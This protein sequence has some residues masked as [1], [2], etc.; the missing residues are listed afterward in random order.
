MTSELYFRK[1]SHFTEN[2]IYLYLFLDDLFFK[3][4]S[5]W[6]EKG[7]ITHQMIRLLLYC[8]L[9]LPFCA[10]LSC[11]SQLSDKAP[12]NRSL[13]ISPEI[14]NQ[15]ISSFAEDSVGH[16]WI[17]TMRGLNKFVVNEF[18]QY[19]SRENPNSLC[20]DQVTQVFRDSRNRLW[21]GTRGGI[22]R[23]TDRDNFERVPIE[24]VSQNVVE[25][26]EDSEG[27]I[28]L[29][30]VGQLCEYQDDINGF[31]V[32]IPNF[33]QEGNWTTRCFTDRNAQ[34]WAVSNNEIRCYETKNL[35]LL[36]STAINFYPHYYF[37]NGNNEIWLVSSTRLTVFDTQT[38]QFLP[39]PTAVQNHPTLLNSIITFVFQYSEK[40]FLLNT[41]NG[42]YLYN[43][44][45]QTVV[46][47]NED[48]FP[49]PA[50]NFRVSTAFLD[51]R[52][53]L[54]LGSNEQG[55]T[56][57]YSY[58]KHFNTNNYLFQ[59]FAG[60]SVIST[61]TDSKDN[62]FLT[63]SNDDVFMYNAKNKTI[64]KI[65][66]K[67]FFPSTEKKYKNRIRSIF[68]DNQ[69]FV[70]LIAEMNHLFR[71]RL[72]GGKFVLEHDFWLPTTVNC[73]A[74]DND[75]NFYAAGFNEN[76]YILKHG[77]TDFHPIEM[78]KRGMYMFTNGLLKLRNGK[79]LVA[80]FHSNL[81]LLSEGGAR[82]DA[83][84]ILSFMKKNP[85]FVPTAVFEDSQGDIWIG[86]L[87]NGLFR[88]S[89]ITEKMEEMP[90]DCD[91]ITSIQEDLQRNIWMGTLFGLT[92]YDH[93]SGKM[94][95][96]YKADGTGGNQFNE[97]ASCR[98]ADGTLIFGGTHGLTFFN[99]SET[100]EKRHIPL[101][102]ENLKINNR[103]VMPDGKI[104]DRHLSYNPVI[105]LQHNENNIMISYSALD[106]AEFPRMRYFCKMESAD[107]NWREMDSRREIYFSNLAP[108]K[109]TFHVK[110]MNH[111]QTVT[112]GENAI[113]IH[114]S[115]AWWWSW[116]AKTLYVL[117]LT[118]LFLIIYKIIKNTR[119]NQSL[120]RQ[121]ELEKEQEKR[122]NKMN[123]N[124]FTNVSHEFRTP[125]TM[126][127]GPVSQLCNDRTIVGENK[128]MLYIIQRS[129]NRM[130]KL[131]NQLL[132][133]NKLEED[134]LKLHVRHADIISELQ[135]ITDIFRINAENKQISLITRGLE[136]TFITWLDC[137]KLDKIVGNLLSN[138]LKF[139]PAGGKIIVSFDLEND[140]IKITVEDS[141][142]GI[143]PDKLEKIFERY[144]QII[145]NENGTYNYGTG[146]GLY[147]AKRLVRLHH[148]TV[149]AGN[150]AEGGA[151]FTLLLPTD[152][153][154]YSAEEK[155]AGREE[156]NEAFPLQTTQQLDKMK[157]EHSDRTPYK[158]LVVDDDTE[159]GHYL[160][161]LLSHEYK[162]INR[163][164]ADSARRA[165]EE[166]TPDLIISD[167]VMPDVSGYEFCRAIKD[168][169]QLC[170]LPVILVTAKTTVESQVQGL[171]AGA[172]AY[173][174]KPFAPDYLLAL[175][176][177]Q[178]SNR[179]KIR[180]ILSSK[181]KTDKSVEK[182]L[183]PHD[184]ALMTE[185]YK[186]METELSNRELNIN[187]IT[188]T[189]KI[190]RTK[191]YYKIK[192]LT[193]INPNTF[194]K[195]YKLNRAAEL[196]AEGKMNISEIADLTGFSTL[197]HFSASF[198]KQFGKSP[199][200]WNV[201]LS[202]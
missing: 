146:I 177:S 144:Y 117:I 61:A 157:S 15:Q 103:L 77:Q 153:N 119:K 92:K 21:I 186:L 34:L 102:F 179:E 28:F 35:K 132:D 18:Q 33:S 2:E 183:S 195:T 196:L 193:G 175:V 71:C 81:T 94:F 38:K 135:N 46:F 166:E 188:D 42:L 50:P 171:E 80:S 181:T 155:E 79:I 139:T 7:S 176:K 131:V 78:T 22:C 41:T 101:V 129:V 199:S 109:Y 24:G 13:I 96:Y 156:Q 90:V 48:G 86:T 19:F 9:A 58:K 160:N 172:D 162:V 167:V 27:R 189:L 110:I 178:L 93:S 49:F 69:D 163:F 67:P 25:I 66:T 63:T 53:N 70:W 106:Y 190:S 184:N 194:F 4:G 17:G 150:S 149:F 20:F 57:E 104:I 43:S 12:E 64:N 14:S 68:I 74:E 30:M 128:K 202:G 40:Q 122:I 100:T 52:K 114:I 82:R 87:F 174:T 182:F 136:D 137:D 165:I 89:F 200:E 60:K 99:P 121:K 6:S 108:G 169:L 126:I 123:M 143:P 180:N 141:G 16:I 138:A 111:D 88:Y 39:T 44:E 154:A 5:C 105:R 73:M 8:L 26:L 142:R 107:E 37:Q 112:E 95:N 51:S 32:V 10:T 72:Q 47:Q 124:F 120:V 147:Y 75:G 197:S 3:K 54:W 23:Y 161:M 97:R 115:S 173:V 76:V 98:T 31:T 55:F 134:V 158:I 187:K 45:N 159:I 125:L 36:F 168:D 62:L 11:N 59:H 201:R 65:E 1:R 83:I 191:L 118:A 130:L 164:D 198:K 84:E 91:D 116:W 185:L 192:G 29:N 85:V 113:K 152:D 170:H 148:G 56:V 145:D 140:F 151:I 133:F 127:S